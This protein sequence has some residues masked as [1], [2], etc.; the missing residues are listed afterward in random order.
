MS[1]CE[2]GKDWPVYTVDPLKRVAIPPLWMVFN[3]EFIDVDRPSSNVHRFA[4][5]VREHKR[6]R[7][8]KPEYNSASRIPFSREK[9]FRDKYHRQISL[10]RARQIKLISLR[11]FPQFV[12][13]S[14]FT[15]IL[16]FY[17]L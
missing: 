14:T 17:E 11:K 3:Y 15:L 10:L 8:R 2:E 9:Y 6:I 5:T 7:E 1:F 13:F 12:P 4:S 16:L